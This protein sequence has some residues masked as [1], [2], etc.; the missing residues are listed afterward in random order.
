MSIGAIIGSYR[1]SGHTAEEI[2]KIGKNFKIFSRK[3]LGISGMK[4]VLSA[5]TMH[6]LFKK[7]LPST[8]EQLDRPV[9][10]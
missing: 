2:F 1:A 10:I 6:D 4:S 3:S 7:T 9:F 8:F 5:D